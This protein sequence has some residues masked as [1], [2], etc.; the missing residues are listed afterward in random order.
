MTAAPHPPATAS[1]PPTPGPMVPRP[2][3]VIANRRDTD[4]TRTLD[5]CPLDDAPFRFAPGQFTMLHAFAVGEVPISISGDPAD[6]SVLR[7]TIR[8]VGAVSAALSA[9]EPGTWL[10]VRGPFGAGWG[11]SDARGGDLVVVAGGIGLAPLRPAMLEVC[12]DRGSYRRV[13]VLYGA[14]TPAEMLFGDDLRRWTEEYDVDVLVT[15][16]RGD[17]T[18]TGNV[19]LVTRLLDR[20]RFD[21]AGTLALVCGPEV[22]MR[23]TAGA[24]VFRGVPAHRLRLSM[25]RNMRCG[26]G[27]CGHC[28]LRE[29]FVCLDGPVLTYEQLAPLIATA[30]L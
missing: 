8:S 3:R 17:A 25:E 30:E 13:S 19:G 5:L 18:W 12:A 10:G 15:V 1:L 26:V 21:P 29:L 7:H 14:R 16:D 20:A 28:Q 9:A 23:H 2:F 22:M 4:D 11:A 27:L 24:L 6:A